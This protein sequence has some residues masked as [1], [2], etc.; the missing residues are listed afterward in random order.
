MNE[1]WREEVFP[2]AVFREYVSQRDN[3]KTKYEG[4]LTPNEM[5]TD[6]EAGKNYFREYTKLTDKHKKNVN[7]IKLLEKINFP[8]DDLQVSISVSYPNSS[9][10]W[11]LVFNPRGLKLQNIGCFTPQD[12]FKNDVEVLGACV[13]S[14]YCESNPV[15]DSDDCAKYMIC[16]ACSQLC[17]RCGEYIGNVDFTGTYGWRLKGEENICDECDQKERWEDEYHQH[18]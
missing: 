6:T 9:P 8:I 5:G 14:L 4:G 2:E 17:W 16:E 7:R 13:K 1:D 3:W 10:H 15:Y 11:S 12:G 18:R